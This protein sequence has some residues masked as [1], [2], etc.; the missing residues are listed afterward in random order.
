MGYYQD[1]RQPYNLGRINATG[2]VHAAYLKV[3]PGEDKRSWRSF[4]PCGVAS[5]QLVR[6]A[7]DVTCKSCLKKDE[8]GER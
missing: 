5:Q 1:E 3:V 2:T 4:A 8:N 6:T 7:R